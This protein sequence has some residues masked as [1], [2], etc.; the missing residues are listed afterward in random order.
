MFIQDKI[1]FETDESINTNNFIFNK[2]LSRSSFHDLEYLSLWDNFS[3]D[4]IHYFSEGI[5]LYKLKKIFEQLIS[6]SIDSPAVVINDY[7]MVIIQHQNIILDHIFTINFRR[8]R[9]KS[10]AD[11]DIKHRAYPC[12]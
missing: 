12:D 1:C 5:C 8:Y 9:W 11:R 3:V 6:K 7:T 10:N 4:A 2:A